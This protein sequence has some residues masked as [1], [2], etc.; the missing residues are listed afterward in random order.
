MG[1]CGRADISGQ[2]DACPWCIC[3]STGERGAES[4]AQDGLGL[5]GERS[6]ERGALAEKRSMSRLTI[7]DT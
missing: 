2:T 4:T 7:Q 5:S 3:V 6:Q 1:V